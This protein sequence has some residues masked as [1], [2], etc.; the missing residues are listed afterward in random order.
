MALSAPKS[1]RHGDLW[2]KATNKNIASS[3][4]PFNPFPLLSNT[5]RTAAGLMHATQF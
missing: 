1:Q 3:F 5:D 4:I 2:K